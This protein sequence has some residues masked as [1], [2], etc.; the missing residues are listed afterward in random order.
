MNRGDWKFFTNAL[1]QYRVQLIQLKSGDYR[2]GVC[3]FFRRPEELDTIEEENSSDLEEATYMP[4]GK[5]CFMPMA[6]W[7]Q[8]V[9]EVA[10]IDEAVNAEIQGK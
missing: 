10:G 2:V 8:F 3:R 6:A 9:D 7:K 1:N 5:S 4:T